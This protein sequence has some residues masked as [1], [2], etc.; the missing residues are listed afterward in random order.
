MTGLN[1]EDKKR[2]GKIAPQFFHFFIP[3]QKSRHFA[4]EQNEA[5]NL[6][7]IATM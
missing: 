7:E 2:N 3:F 5:R 6:C 4:A 1:E